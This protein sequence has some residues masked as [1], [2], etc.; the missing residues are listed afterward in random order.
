MTPPFSLHTSNSS[1]RRSKPKHENNAVIN[2]NRCP[3]IQTQSHHP[4]TRTL[5]HRPAP[6]AARPAPPAYQ[7]QYQPQYATQQH[8]QAIYQQ[9]RLAAKQPIFTPAAEQPRL[10]ASLQ[11]QLLSAQQYYDE[12]PAA[13]AASPVH[14]SYKNGPVQFG[15]APVQELQARPQPQARSGRGGGILD[16][17]ARDYALPQNSAPPLHDISFGYY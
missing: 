15:P 4:L 16:Q 14:P 7:P 10:S 3:P 13:A 5:S 17:L 8:T 12:Q 11:S 9:P 1:V 2:K 6:A